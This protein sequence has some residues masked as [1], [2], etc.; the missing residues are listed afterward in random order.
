MLDLRT[1]VGDSRF[2]T[3]ANVY[4]ACVSVAQVTSERVSTKFGPGQRAASY[5]C[6]AFLE[7]STKLHGGVR[8][9]NPPINQ[10]P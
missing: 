3:H 6:L 2:T 4:A 9:V 7:V 10:R 5:N 1:R 8:S